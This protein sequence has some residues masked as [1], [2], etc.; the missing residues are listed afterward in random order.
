MPRRPALLAALAAATLLAPA[1]ASGA[2]RPPLLY[3]E[4]GVKVAGQDARLTGKARKLARHWIGKRL[5][6]TC[7]SL[8]PQLADGQIYSVSVR[9]TRFAG[10]VVH[11]GETAGADY[12]LVQHP[13]AAGYSEPVALVAL[14]KAGGAF[15]QELQTAIMLNALGPMTAGAGG[16]PLPADEVVKDSPEIYVALPAADASPPGGKVGYWTDGA[17]HV[18]VAMI[19]P[20]GRR[21]FI[22]SEADGVIRTNTLGYLTAVG[23]L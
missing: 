23:L 11:L 2:Q 19:A 6:T 9:P 14:T 17:Q 7:E 22:E 21:L 20:S 12:C 13:V 15:I 10:R 4:N 1:A 18:V 8:S 16:R 3:P 5:D